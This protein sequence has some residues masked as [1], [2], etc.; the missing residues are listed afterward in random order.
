MAK[1]DH[2]SPSQMRSYLRCP[3]A[4]EFSYIKGIKTPPSGA[5]ICGTAYHDAVAYYYK[6]GD[7]AYPA[8]VFSDSWERQLHLHETQDEDSTV[9]FDTTDIDWNDE[10]PGDVKDAG[11]ALTQ[12]YCR[13]IAPRYNPVTVETW[14]EVYIKGIKLVTIT[15]L[16]TENV[17]AD[18][19]VSKRRFSDAD[20]AN[21]IQVTA[22]TYIERKPFE[23]HMALRQ[24]IN[25]VEIVNDT[26]LTRQVADFRFFENLVVDITNAAERNY[27][28]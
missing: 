4:Y 8:D 13:D 9:E 20:K 24:K 23:F 11:I 15:D 1:I 10:K 21:D 26:T 19:K 17:I 14:K 28:S 6:S 16:V 7:I 2:L 12:L 22:Y 27:D 25:A 3:K 18:H 5:M